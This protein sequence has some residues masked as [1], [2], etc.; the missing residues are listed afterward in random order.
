[1]PICD[2][3]DILDF[4]TM[5]IT[6]LKFLSDKLNVQITKLGNNV[7]TFEYNKTFLIKIIKGNGIALQNLLNSR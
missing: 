4:K 7:L 3:H 5:P 1:M 6:L 2:N